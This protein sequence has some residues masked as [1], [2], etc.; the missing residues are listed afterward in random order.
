M[1]EPLVWT[2]DEHGKLEATPFGQRVYHIY[3]RQDG[4]WM[5]VMYAIDGITTVARAF[6]RTL[7]VSKQIADEWEQALSRYEHRSVTDPVGE[8][9]V[10][11]MPRW[12]GSAP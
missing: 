3:P 10:A 4:L 11:R 2:G 6:G 9:D 1:R 7:D 5:V 12:R 8:A